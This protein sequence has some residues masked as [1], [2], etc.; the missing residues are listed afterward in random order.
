MAPV[1]RPDG[2]KSVRAPCTLWL[3][4]QRDYMWSCWRPTTWSYLCDNARSITHPIHD[5]IWGDWGKICS[6]L[7]TTAP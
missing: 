6:R 2:T 5:G 1:A 4:R 3:W 7:A